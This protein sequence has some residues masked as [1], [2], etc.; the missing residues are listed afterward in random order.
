MH[1]EAQIAINLMGTFEGVKAATSTSLKA[2]VGKIK[3]RIDPAKMLDVYQT[4]VDTTQLGIQGMTLLEELTKTS[5]ILEH[6][7]TVV[8]FLPKDKCTLQDAIVNDL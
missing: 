3:K 8:T 6:V 1:N 7:I 2:L 4:D 5:L